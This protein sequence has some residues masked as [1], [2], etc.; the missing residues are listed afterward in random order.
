MIE[1][2]LIKRVLEETLAN[3]GELAELYIEDST[4][5]SIICEDNKIEQIISGRD[6]GAGLRL[7]YDKRSSYAYTN[8]INE[9]AL[10][11]LAKKVR[12]A[13]NR[14]AGIVLD[15]T[16][17]KPSV[18]FPI[19]KPIDKVDT[20]KKIEKVKIANETGR[21]LN[22]KIKQVKVMY[23]DGVRRV[24]IANSHG[25]LAEDERTGIIFA[26]HVVASDGKFIQTGYES[27]GGFMGFELFDQE[28]PERIARNA[29]LRAIMML[30]AENAPAGE[31]TVVLSCEAG[32]T[33]IHEAIGHGLEGDFIQQGLSVYSKRLGEKIASPM[34]TVVD[35]AT[36]PNKRGSYRFDDEGTPSQR[37]VLVE[38]GILKQFMYDRLSAMKAGIPSSGNGRRMSYKFRPIPRMTNTF[39][40]PGMMDPDEILTS[41]KRGLFVKKMGG[42]EVNIVNGDFVFDVSEGYLIEDGK[43]KQPVRGATLTGNGPEV[44][45]EIDMVGN[46]L[47]FGIGTCGKDGQ[48][49]PVSDAQ[50]T[51]RIPKI[52]VGG[53]KI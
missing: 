38:E 51:L 48:G 19:M 43:I 1:Q 39:I 15:M 11:N 21:G 13:S 17:K 52:I 29:A 16:V 53:T 50:P 28:P 37:T 12:S 25:E 46:D 31:M 24:L 30:E 44:L 5:I 26:V 47:G 33:M 41:V 7:I 40:A 9:S 27:A 35:D 42:G 6:A 18:D 2:I 32:G 49:A 4:S 20:G 10:I 14:E 23:Q 8:D 45:R 36:L 22:N 3:G 34:V